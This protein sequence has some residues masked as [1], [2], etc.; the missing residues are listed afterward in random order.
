MSTIRKAIVT[1]ERAWSAQT[2]A[3]MVRLVGKYLPSNYTASLVDDRVVIEGTDVAGW[4]FDDYVRPRLMSGGIYVGEVEVV[5]VD[6]DEEGGLEE[7]EFICPSCEE[8]HDRDNEG[9]Y[10]SESTG[11]EYC[12]GCWDSSFQYAST[13]WLVGDPDSDGPVKYLVTD[14]G[15]F[16]AEYLEEVTE[17]LLT[18]TYVRT[19][20]WRGYHVTK[21]VGDW[22]EAAAGWTTGNWG[23][24]ISDSKQDFNRWVEALIQGEITLEHPVWVIFDLTSNVFST[25]AGVFIPTDVEADVAIPSL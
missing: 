23:D 13:A 10:F 14:Y 2:P 21:P 17:P 9:S 19:D 6:D 18:R 22:V 5:E 7:S 3:D 24:A 16:E 1:T 4:T 8:K 12:D 15:T 20:G 25:A 11:E